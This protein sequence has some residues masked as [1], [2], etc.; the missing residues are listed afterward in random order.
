M[1][2]TQLRTFLTAAFQ[3]RMKVLVK[4]QPGIGKSDLIDD[5]A[6]D[7]QADV[8]TRHPS[9]EDPTDAK[10]MPAIVNGKDG[11]N[12]EAHFLPFGDLNKMIRA[13]RLTVVHLE[14]FG[15]APHAVQAAYMQLLLRRS[16][17]GTAI[18]PH[19]VFCASTNDT[20]HRAGVNTILE[21]VK[22]RFDAIIELTPHLDDWCGWAFQ[23]EIPPELIA[24]IRFRP[25][26]L[27]KFEPTRELSNSPNP[28]T[29]A[30]VGR[31][32]A[33]GVRSSEVFAGAAGQGFAA[34]FVGFLRVFEQLPSID[35]ILLNPTHE[36]VPTNPSAQWAVTTALVPRFTK[37]TARAV[38]TY[39]ARLP[40][41]FEVCLIRDAQR[42]HR[43]LCTTPEFVDWS[44][45]NACPSPVVYA[46][47]SAF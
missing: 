20:S 22:S 6:K 41:E 17:N 13:E 16:V 23:H 1:S 4:G 35:A 11:S 25:E 36:P 3:N 46:P 18:S 21:P 31:W 38:F 30:A 32:Y 34:E 37:G 2:P 47:P 27:S 24:F 40:K 15:Q 7:A 28:R 39:A 19:V 9:V 33:Q 14:D 26:L 42:L 43:D 29:V 8:L 44:V 10:G 12:Q 45:K 5:A